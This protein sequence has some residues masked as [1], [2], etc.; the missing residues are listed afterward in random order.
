MITTLLVPV[1]GAVPNVTVLF[2]APDN[3]NSPAPGVP[4]VNVTATPSTVAD[5]AGEA[6]AFSLRVKVV[7][8]P[9]PLNSCLAN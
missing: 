5:G 7:V 9:S 3:P 8:D 2:P 6:S 4:V 1:A